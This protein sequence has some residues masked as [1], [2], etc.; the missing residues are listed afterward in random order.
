MAHVLLSVVPPPQ[1]LTVSC[2]PSLADLFRRL[3]SALRRYVASRFPR[4]CPGS[5][6]DAVSD[7]FLIAAESPKRIESAFAKGGEEHVQSLLYLI[8]WRCARGSLCRGAGAWETAY[9]E[10]PE[11][12]SWCAPSQEVL[13]ELHL[14]LVPTVEACARE[15]CV[16]HAEA[17]AN[18]L[19]DRLATGDD[20]L[21]VAE[22]HGV[23]R[24]YL[25]QARRRAY[26]RMCGEG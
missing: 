1:E 8:A 22:R 23:A 17:I 13:A 3:A 25:N 24:E 19:F 12:S 21:V 14:H 6:D 10:L 16:R 9:D 26:R 2:S 7:T 15:V 18:A 11:S 4:L 5:V 20:D